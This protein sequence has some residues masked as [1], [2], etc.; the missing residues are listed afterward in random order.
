MRATRAVWRI[1]A[2]AAPI[3]WAAAVLGLALVWAYAWVLDDAFV[4]FR[5]L[6][7]ALFLG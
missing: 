3:E 4:Y 1:A 6:D 5:Y 2:S 7:N